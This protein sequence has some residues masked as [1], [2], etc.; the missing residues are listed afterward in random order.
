ML[1]LTR[2]GKPLKPAVLT[3]E[4]VTVAYLIALYRKLSNLFESP[5]LPL[6]SDYSYQARAREAA[7][8]RKARGTLFG[9]DLGR[10]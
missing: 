1:V 3:M 4:G 10:F 5:H 9:I 7:R 2:K 8:Q 6:D